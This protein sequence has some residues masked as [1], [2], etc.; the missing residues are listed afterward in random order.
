MAQ[1]V[2]PPRF[3]PLDRSPVGT[4]SAGGRHAPRGR[5]AEDD[6]TSRVPDRHLLAG[7]V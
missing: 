5:T 3:A 4:F 2:T 6:I 1:T 7:F